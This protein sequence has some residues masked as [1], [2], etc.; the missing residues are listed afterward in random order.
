MKAIIKGKAIQI[1]DKRVDFSSLFSMRTIEKSNSYADE[2]FYN[3]CT[4]NELYEEFVLPLYDAEMFIQDNSIRTIDIHEADEELMPVFLCACARNNIHLIGREKS[5]V[6]FWKTRIN[7]VG[8]FMYLFLQQL[9]Q[10]YNPLKGSKDSI[11]FI[12]TKS[13]KQKFQKIL[14]VDKL[15]EIKPGVGSIY[16][17]VRFAE[18]ISL[19]FKAKKLARRYDKDIYNYLSRHKMLQCS[20]FAKYYY[21][22]RLVH[23]AYYYLV[24]DYIIKNGN[25]KTFYTGNN[26]DRFAVNEELLAKRHRMKLVCIPHGIEY[27]YKFPNC[28]VGDVFYTTSENAA[29]ALNRLY[30][31]DKFV[32]SAKTAEMMFKMDGVKA[33]ERKVVYFSEPREFYVNI[34]IL[35]GLFYQLANN[36][37]ELY[38]KLHPIDDRNN[39]KELWDLGIKE[40]EDFKEA[41]CGNIC[42]SR[43]S[44]ILIEATY[45]NSLAVAIVIN[46][47]DKTVFESFPSLFDEKVAYFEDIT[48]AGDFLVKEFQRR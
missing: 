30:D 46:N 44:T 26:L 8:V 21:S 3:T 9:K 40:I 6:L 16:K 19:L 25:W 35:K 7:K 28:F 31:T 36:G 4:V 18:R 41:V 14:D 27:G 22:R 48:Q 23:T 47:K 11:V 1:G 20:N 10:K 5:I 34:E 15:D 32:F 2:Y 13:V 38:L 33:V 37:I 17:Q 45:N 42:V 24:Q 29:R 39:Y 12:R 43:K